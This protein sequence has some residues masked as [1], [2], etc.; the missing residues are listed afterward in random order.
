MDLNFFETEIKRLKVQ[1]PTAYSEERMKIFF[2][3]FRDVS[4]FD[5]RDAVTHCLATCKG[6]PLLGELTEAIHVARNNYFAQKRIEEE[7]LNRGMFGLE[8]NGAADPDFAKKCVELFKQFDERKITREQFDQGC[9]LLEQASKLF[10]IK[11]QNSPSIDKA[12][13]KPYKDD[14]DEKPF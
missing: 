5:F 7:K 3:A 1:W 9:D 6:A 10:P 14:E 12:T 13:T 2:N 11:K 4:N 8:N